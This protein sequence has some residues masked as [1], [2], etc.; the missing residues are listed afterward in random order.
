MTLVTTEADNGK[1]KSVILVDVTR[2]STECVV[3]P[4][5]EPWMPEKE[6]Q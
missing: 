5:A 1:E 4:A 3:S 2:R 6:M